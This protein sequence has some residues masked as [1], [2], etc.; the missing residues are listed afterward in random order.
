VVFTGGDPFTRPDIIDIIKEGIALEWPKIKV[1]TKHPLTREVLQELS[2][3]GGIS[4]S[5]DTLDN[6]IAEKMTRIPKFAT[7]IMATI[8]KA[9][10]AGIRVQVN[11]VATKLNY[12]TIPHLTETVIK[13]KVDKVVISPF[14]KR[15]VA[16]NYNIGVSEEQWQK[17][18]TAIKKI[19]TELQLAPSRI[20]MTSST[21]YNNR[22]R[23]VI[24]EIINERRRSITKI[25]PEDQK[26]DACLLKCSAGYD[27][28]WIFPDGTVGHCD[29]ISQK[30]SGKIGKESILEIWQSQEWKDFLNPEHHKYHSSQC[31]N[32][33]HF[34]NCEFRLVC[35]ADS[36][37]NHGQMYAPPV[38]EC[39]FYE[40][41]PKKDVG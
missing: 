3:I 33:G 41:R 7:K 23:K 21:T 19:K 25:I 34:D 32:C 36:L 5:L 39:Y 26:N 17:L 38:K 13:M 30:L 9:L 29:S 6:N 20:G 14:T 35:F 31:Y 12:E 8:Q 37:A 10:D 27:R 4:W 18:R 28:L 15:K 22:S 16:S 2:G 11:T 40:K 1:I 24:A